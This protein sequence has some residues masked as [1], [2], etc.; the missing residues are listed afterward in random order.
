M[1]CT[2][3]FRSNMIDLCENTLKSKLLLPK[4]SRIYIFKLSV[5]RCVVTGYTSID[6][7]KC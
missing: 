1:I 3:V 5:S 2:Q 7:A 4:N 6:D